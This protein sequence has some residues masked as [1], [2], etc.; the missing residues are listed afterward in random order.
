MT[1]PPLA[2]VQARIA[3]TRLPGKMLL[4]LGGKP[5]VRWATDAAIKAFGRENVVAAIPASAA[6][7]ELARVLAEACEVFRWDGPENDV[8]GRFRVCA[9]RYRWHPMSVVVRVTPDDWRKRP[10]IMRRVA[11][12]ERHPVEIGAEAFTLARLR[13]ADNVISKAALREHLTH[14]LW[15]RS[16]PPPAPSLDV[17]WSID[18]A[19]DLAAA[20]AYVASWPSRE[21]VMYA[22]GPMWAGAF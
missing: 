3:S 15:P 17:P 1:P 14:I 19:D 22:S 16:A 21:A 18:T 9:D 7:D 2:I 8:L 13:K 11:S 12:G 5:L 6:N 20:R 10:L 4:D